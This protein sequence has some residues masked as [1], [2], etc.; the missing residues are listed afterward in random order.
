[1]NKTIIIN[2]NGIVFHI[3]EDAYEILKNYM[4]DVKRHFMNSADSLEITTDIENRIAEMFSEMLQRENKQVIV[5]QDVIIVVEQMGSVADFE[6]ADADAN[7]ASNSFAYKN[8]MESRR[9]F[10]DPDDHLIGGVCAGIA[11]YFD[12]DVVWIRLAFAL[13]SVFAG[14]GLILYLVLWIVVP[15]AVTRA[16]RMAMKGEKQNLKGFKKNFEDELSSVKQHF[17]NFGNEARPFVYKTRDLGVFFRGAGRV[18]VKMLGVIILMMCFGFIVAIVVVT[19]AFTVLG[20]EPIGLFPF[21]IIH[22]EL[23]NRVYI[24]A[25]LVALIPLVSIIL[26]TLSGIFKVGTIGRSTGSIFLVVWIVALGLLIYDAT[27]IASEFR[28][29]ARFTQTINIKPTPGNTYYLKLNDIKYFSHEDSVRLNIKDHFQNMI[30]SDDDAN[31]FHNEP[32]SVSIRIE[33]SDVNKPVLEESF[34]ASGANFEDALFNARNTSYV[35]AQQDTI[36][37]FDYALRKRPNIYFHAEEVE[38][39]LKMPL[40]AKLVIDRRL[41]NYLRDTNFDRCERTG[42][43]DM[44]TSSTF[45]MT[46]DGLQCKVDTIVTP[47]IDSAGKK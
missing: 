7:E 24:S 21:N 3:E 39:T 22:N 20:K 41:D 6:N 45:I 1:M 44:E 16:D 12:V 8:N 28:E 46:N 29:S 40:N 4:T 5:E 11:N 26:A 47:K 10:R 23:A 13:T 30:V 37:K 42:K 31:G 33:R 9:L 32:R 34:R 25:F 38:L 18:F 2:M 27:K 35:F 15:K 14:S 43:R 19:V 36:L 17:G